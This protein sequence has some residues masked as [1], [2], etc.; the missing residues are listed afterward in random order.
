MR[1]VRQAATRVGTV[2][3]DGQDV[4][5]SVPTTE[6]PTGG[7]N[8][9]VVDQVTAAGLRRGLPVALVVVPDTGVALAWAGGRQWLPAG[10]PTDVVRVLTVIDPRWTWWSARATAAPLIDAGVPL[11]TCWDLAAVGRLLGG[12]RRDDPAAVWAAA[13]DL[14]EPATAQPTPDLFDLDL[15]DDSADVGPI[16]ADGQLSRDWLTGRWAS[17]PE[18]AQRWASVVLEL[19]A[20]QDELLRALP[21]PRAR[22]GATPLA[23]LT[24]R[25]ESTAALLA[26]ELEHDGLPI[27]RAAATDLLTAT[28]GPRP[29]GAAEE[30][31]IRI[32]RDRAVLSRFPGPAVDLRSPA[33]VK[34]LLARIGLDLPD[35][36]SW[37]LERHEETVQPV[38]ALLAWRKAE[39]IA[40]TYGWAWLDRQVG[41]DGRLRGAWSAADAAA[42]RMTAQAGLHNLPATFRPVVRAE[43][44]HVLLRADLGQIEPR[45]LAVVSGDTALTEAARE[46]DMYAPV[47]AALACDR[48]TAK[49]AVLAAMYG[50]TSG[51]AGAALRDM[52]RTYPAAMSYLRHAEQAGVDGT[53]LRTYGGRR[54]QL[55]HPLAGSFEPDD[56]QAI[57]AHGRYARNAVVQGAAAELFKAWAGTVRDGLVAL[58]GQIVLCLHDELLVHV[59]AD[60]AESAKTLLGD[61]LTST[62]RWWAAGSAVRFV[63]DI[64][65]GDSWADAH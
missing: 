62:A 23:V 39:R 4:L 37:R 55:M 3:D 29:T 32:E 44:G 56:R 7:V 41:A 31:A 50:Q 19:Q 53:D 65:I 11:R 57:A 36:R 14:P 2:G 49:V 28:I 25:S 35:T 46:D 33:Q 20:R 52:D 21:D 42:G 1:P 16:R 64:G 38:A 8:V 27:D 51:A 17:G 9:D 12:L 30:A 24:A 10:R 59:A 61:A 47:A 18:S 26:V 43:A 34:N 6:R 22:S 48:P 45:V 63:A 60:R 13:H 40:T 15:D 5:D 58:D 54:L